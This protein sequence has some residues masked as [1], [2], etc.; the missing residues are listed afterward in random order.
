MQLSPPHL[1]VGKLRFRNR[2]G[3]GQWCPEFPLQAI[4]RLL[5]QPASSLASPLATSV[6]LPPDLLSF[7]SQSSQTTSSMKP[8]SVP[9]GVGELELHLFSSAL[10]SLSFV[11]F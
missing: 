9:A 4:P 11:C 10:L 3:T 2:P 6:L 7:L 8:W 5:P 1:K